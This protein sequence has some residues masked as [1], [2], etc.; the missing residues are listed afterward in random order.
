MMKGLSAVLSVLSSL[1]GK[2]QQAQM[3]AAL[4]AAQ[5]A[6]EEAQATVPVN[7]GAL[8]ASI[9]VKPLPNGAVT[10]AAKPYASMVEMGSLRTSP[11]PFL[12]PAAQNA[13]YPLRVFQALEEGLH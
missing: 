10:Q 11:Q 9:A 4:E 13:Q 3:K 2:A 1:P 7:T 12:L 6:Q 5:A 8:R